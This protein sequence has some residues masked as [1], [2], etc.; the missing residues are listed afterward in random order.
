M[1]SPGLKFPAEIRHVIWEEV[2]NT[3]RNIEVGWLLGGVVQYAEHE[4]SIVLD[5]H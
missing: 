4:D 1:F 3:P 5:E 2:A